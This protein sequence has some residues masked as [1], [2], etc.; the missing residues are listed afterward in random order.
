MSRL[1]LNAGYD[2]VTARDGREAL[3]RL[4]Q[5]D[6]LPDLVISDVMMPRMDGREL[7]A[8]IRG[9]PPPLRDVPIIFLSGII[10]V[11]FRPIL[12]LCLAQAVHD[13]GMNNVELGAEDYLV[14]PF[15]VRDLLMRV[16]VRIQRA[17]SP[18][19]SLLKSVCWCVNLSASDT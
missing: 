7:L 8:A 11:Q 1:L 4:A 10:L 19:I 9:C 14:K 3:E 6:M 13:D 5:P 15:A 17:A 16:S 2:V 18:S 12:I